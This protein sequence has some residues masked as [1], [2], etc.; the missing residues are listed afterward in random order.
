MI[1]TVLFIFSYMVQKISH[2]ILVNKNMLSN[3]TDHLNHA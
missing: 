3:T 1:K 2:N